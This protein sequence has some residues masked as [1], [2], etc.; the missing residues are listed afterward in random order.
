LVA[1]VA[2]APD[3]R[4]T[5]EELDE[6]ASCYRQLR[7]QPEHT[8]L[9]AGAL[10]AAVLFGTADDLSVGAQRRER[11]WAGYVGSLHTEESSLIEA[12]TAALDGQFALV[13]YR[14]EAQR[15]E[16]LS[17][18]FGLQA[19]YISRRAGL[20]YISTSALAIAKHLAARPNVDGLEVW[21]RTGPHFGELTN[22]DAVKRFAPATARSYGSGG[23]RCE[24]YWS[25]KVERRIAAM[26]LEPAARECVEVAT[27]AWRRR[28]AVDGGP[29]ARLSSAW[30][31]LS[32]GYDTRLAALLLDRAGVKFAT[33]T[34]GSPADPDAVIAKR[35]ATLGG[36]RWE[37]GTLSGD[38]PQRCE[39]LIPDAIAWGDG[40]LEATQLAQVMA[41]QQER[42][43]GPTLLFNGGGGEHWR[44]YAWKQEFP[45]GG[46]RKHVDFDR[47]VL[48]RFMHPID[49]S[50]FKSDPTRRAHASLVE[51]CRD[52]VAPYADELNSVALDMLYAYKAMAHFGAYQSAARGTLRVELPFYAKEAFLAAFSVAPRHR[53]S[54]RLAR[55]AIARLN[56][57][58]AELP[59]TH[60]DLASPLQVRNAHRFVHFYTTRLRG[61]ARKLTQNLPGP[62]IG[63]LTISTPKGIEAA[64]RQVLDAFLA[65]TDADPA[66]MRSGALYDGGALQRLAT[67]HAATTAGWAT[68][69]RIITAERTLEAV[70]AWVG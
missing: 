12:G 18:P 41:L 61:A 50:V 16:V 55:N 47:W 20:T 63:A 51:R 33:N 62:T 1:I 44:D 14:A 10:G 29:M 25:P 5:D 9:S 57:R 35:I 2:E 42:G 23:M 36:W 68:L 48:A 43:R 40:M 67:S 54:H 60:G 4:A 37:L 58:I 49:A 7:S 38:W 34:N 13:R 64:R 53:N 70:D 28:F 15:Y 26:Q 52:Y 65:R 11:S 19:L 39:R 17:D 8:R 31:D 45:F 24:T 6:F 3:A 22:W 59:T 21:L 27:E 32:G 30:C 66:K 46:R 69:G 56:R